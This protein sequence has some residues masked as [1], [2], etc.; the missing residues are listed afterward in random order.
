M[1]SA[2]QFPELADRLRASLK[3]DPS[4]YKSDAL[5]IMTLLKMKEND[6]AL[7]EFRRLAAHE[8]D[9]V[10]APLVKQIK[11][12]FDS[13]AKTEE[14]K[15]RL[16]AALKDYRVA[17]GVAILNELPV[18][19][20]QREILRISLDLYQG[21]YDQARERFLKIPFESYSEKEQLGKVSD[22]IAET[23]TAYKKLMSRVDVYL[24]S[25][26]A[27]VYCSSPLN[28]DPVNYPELA[29]MSA[30]EFIELVSNL[31]QMAPLS[32]DVRSLVFH[33]QLLAG[34]Y[35][36]LEQW[37][38]RLLREKGSIRIAFFASDRFF[39]LVIDSRQKRLYTEPDSHLFQ[40]RY[41]AG[42]RYWANLAPFD[43]SFDQIKS[44]SQKAWTD[45]NYSKPF[46]VKL[47]PEGV[48]PNFALMNILR[49]TAGEQA[50]AM[51]MKNLGRYILHVIGR[52]DVRAELTDPANLKGPSSG[53]WETAL[54][55]IGGAMSS[56][57]AVRAQALEGVQTIDAIR[58]SEIAK[59]QA[60]QAAWDSFTTRYTFNLIEADAFSALEQ[61][62][63]VL[64]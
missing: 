42:S 18:S 41:P 51:A 43:L 12:L 63:G 6:A 24:Y 64:N 58:A 55:I 34:Q 8:Q 28:A 39:N 22:N 53:G 45:R 7:T 33:A 3:A 9:P 44:L 61:L 38:D 47:V 29:S 13:L 40:P 19:P 59:Y 20:K 35:D 15:G 11:T 1:Y 56:N 2:G 16:I 31:I 32:D 10:A 21:K 4:D 17:D 54:L 30:K 25:P 14:A 60:Q 57:A 46:A 27:M 52:N 36:E 50:E 49:C 26:F 23:E 48:A 37:G 5:L 62:L